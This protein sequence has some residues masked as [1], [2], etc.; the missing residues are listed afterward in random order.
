MEI[1]INRELEGIIAARVA[2][3]MNQSADDVLREALYL[4]V[5]RDQLWREHPDV[6]DHKIQTA[7]DEMARGEGLTE[8]QLL[9]HIEN[10]KKTFF[11]AS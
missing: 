7:M 5:E 8:T 10:R 11:S 9:Q 4:L 1:Q 3:G 2:Q 6:L